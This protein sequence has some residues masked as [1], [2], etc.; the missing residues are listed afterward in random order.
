MP[1]LTLLDFPNSIIGYTIQ[2]QTLNLAGTQSVVTCGWR[3]AAWSTTRSMLPRIASHVA[4]VFRFMPFDGKPAGKGGRELR[5]NEE[6]DQATR[7][8]EWSA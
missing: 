2:G 3:V 1:G 5:V 6:P 7:N 4:D 8:T